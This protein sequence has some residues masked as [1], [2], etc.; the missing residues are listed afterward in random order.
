MTAVAPKTDDAGCCQDRDR[1]PT[2]P[3]TAAAASGAMAAALPCVNC[4]RAMNSVRWAS[5]SAR[6]HGVQ[7]QSQQ[8]PQP[9]TRGQHFDGDAEPVIR[10][11]RPVGVRAIPAARPDHPSSDRAP[12]ARPS[13]PQRGCKQPRPGHRGHDGGRREVGR[14]GMELGD[15]V[16]REDRPIQRG[17]EPEGEETA[18]KPAI[19]TG[20]RFLGA[21][22][23]RT[24]RHRPLNPQPQQRSHLPGADQRGEGKRRRRPPTT[25]CRSA[26]HAPGPAAA[27]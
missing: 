16:R 27:A 15:H 9:A 4:I 17:A 13:L 7:V 18:E 19:E 25:P 3:T 8:V 1:A 10:D 23:A 26:G 21:Q 20:A 12:R 24:L 14:R 5:P 22:P 11:D 6:F 2:T